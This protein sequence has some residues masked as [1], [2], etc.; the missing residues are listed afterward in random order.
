LRVD[1]C[2]REKDPLLER[3]I[4]RPEAVMAS[5]TVLKHD[6]T[7]TVTVV[8]DAGHEWVI[9]RYN[10]KSPWHAVRRAFRSSRAMICWRA[11][12]WL[13]AAG[14]DTIRPVAMMEERYL[15][16]LRGRSYLVYEFV[17][18]EPLDRVLLRQGDNQEQCLERACAIVD[19]LTAH[20]IVHGDL[21]CTNFIVSGDRV[22]L[23]DLDSTR[24]VADGGPATDLDNDRRRFLRNWVDHPQLLKQFERRLA[25]STAFAQTGSG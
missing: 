2:S 17:A 18:G 20:G 7:T 12:G 1:T 8:K 15:K 16:F 24:R 14:I 10:T 21:K 13:Q 9:K 3:I 11:A 25:A 5:G 6:G 19:K 4:A 22:V 23:V